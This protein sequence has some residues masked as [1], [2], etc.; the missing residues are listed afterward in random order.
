MRLPASTASNGYNPARMAGS[1]P[2][3]SHYDSGV[4]AT[5]TP[6]PSGTLVDCLASFARAQPD[7]PA[8]LFKGARVSYGELERLTDACAAAFAAP[9]VRSVLPPKHS[10]V[11][12]PLLR[13]LF[14]LLR[15]KKDG[16]RIALA[17]GDH[18]FAHLLLV[19]RDHR[20][21]PVTVSPDDTAVL[22]MSG[23]TTGTPKGVVGTHSAY[24]IAGT[25]IQAWNR[26]VLQGPDDVPFL[27]L[28]LFHVYRNAGLPA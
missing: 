21:P 15:E 7:H 19:N 25:Q 26:S 27:P 1:S 20:P 3:L 14:T 11:H 2:W 17:P 16:D 6:Y 28:P 13:V 5:L 10:N 24:V 23:G 4:P 22:L 18:D 9:G 12:P 8:L